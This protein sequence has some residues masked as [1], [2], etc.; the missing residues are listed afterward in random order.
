MSLQLSS[1]YVQSSYIQTYHNFA[2]V[3]ISVYSTFALASRIIKSELCLSVRTVMLRS[4]ISFGAIKLTNNSFVTRGLVL[5][6]KYRLA[7]Y[8]CLCTLFVLTSNFLLSQYKKMLVGFF[9][10]KRSSLSKATVS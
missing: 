6:K 2:I 10:M 5:R 8:D 7:G 4:N 3:F 9:Y 1:L